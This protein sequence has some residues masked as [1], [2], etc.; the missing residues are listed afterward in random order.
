MVK[1]IVLSTNLQYI[2]IQQVLKYT[3]TGKESYTTTLIF[4]KFRNRQKVVY[5]IRNKKDIM[6][7]DGVIYIYGS[8]M[9]DSG[10]ATIKQL[11]RPRAP[12]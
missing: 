2:P 7:S 10:R 9:G 12:A 3:K 11:Y 6:E 1:T 4:Y 8:Y 5:E